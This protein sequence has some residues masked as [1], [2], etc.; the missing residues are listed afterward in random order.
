MSP[1]D[2]CLVKRR[3]DEPRT[4]FGVSGPWGLLGEREASEASAATHGRHTLCGG[5]RRL[6]EGDG[7]SGAV[8]P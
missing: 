1:T 7:V 3:R 8:P 4:P 6:G 5:E 2:L